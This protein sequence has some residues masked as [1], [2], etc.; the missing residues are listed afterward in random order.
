MTP[1]LGAELVLMV[2]PHGVVRDVFYD[3][4]DENGRSYFMSPPSVSL[5]LTTSVTTFMMMML[6]D[7]ER[8]F[9]KLLLPGSLDVFVN[10]KAAFAADGKRMDVNIEIPSTCGS[11]PSDCLVV[12]VRCPPRASRSIYYDLAY[13]HGAP[14]FGSFAGVQVKEPATVA[15]FCDD[16]FDQIC[17]LLSAN[18]APSCLTVYESRAVFEAGGKPLDA[19]FVHPAVLGASVKLGLLVVVSWGALRG[20]RELK[21]SEQAVYYRVIDEHGEP[22]FRQLSRVYVEGD[23]LVKEFRNAAFDRVSPMLHTD[24]EPSSLHVFGNRAAFD[25]ANPPMG[26]D[27][28]ITVELDQS[29]EDRMVVV[30]PTTVIER[31]AL[32]RHRERKRRSSSEPQGEAKHLARPVKKVGSTMRLSTHRFNE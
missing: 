20:G 5:D 13:E 10:R 11:S 24:T 1:S 16:V 2:P 19:H 7:H 18:A 29:D 30:V 22:Y 6:K 15:T 12:V 25:E 21:P 32:R 28:P 4:V 17:G 27:E 14:N 9:P 3:I 8:L 26:D 23:A 31:I